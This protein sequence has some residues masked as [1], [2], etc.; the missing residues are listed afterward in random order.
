MGLRLEILMLW[1]FPEKSD[2]K[3]GFHE[4]LIYRGELPKKDGLD[5]LQ[6]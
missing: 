3:R 6:I 2:F 4:K 5:S 1:G